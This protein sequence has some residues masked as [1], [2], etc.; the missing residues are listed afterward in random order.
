MSSSRAQLSPAHFSKHLSTLSMQISSL[1][2]VICFLSILGGC[3][4]MNGCQGPSTP[5]PNK[6]KVQSAIQVRV[7]ESGLETIGDVVTPIIKDAL[8]PELSSCLPGDS[9]QSS[10]IQWR[11]CNM[12]TC[13]NGELGCNVSIGVGE[14]ITRKC[15]S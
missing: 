9:G 1:L 3:D 7:T 5:F 15:R 2:I 10:F 12:E 4:G 14:V 8:P 6:D 11:Y 13:D